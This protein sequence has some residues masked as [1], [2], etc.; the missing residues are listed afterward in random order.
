MQSISQRFWIISHLAAC[1]KVC[2]ES[3][4]VAVQTIRLQ[5]HEYIIH[6][7]EQAVLARQSLSA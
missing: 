4:R 3:Y 1:E 2:Q 5:A 7:L 6:M